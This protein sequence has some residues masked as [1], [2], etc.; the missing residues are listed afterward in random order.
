MLS[1]RPILAHRKRLGHKT[2]PALD[3]AADALK[4][5]KP[6]PPAEQTK[7]NRNEAQQHHGGSDRPQQQRQTIGDQ[8]PRHPA[9]REWHGHFEGI[10]PVRFETNAPKEKQRKPEPSLPRKMRRIGISR[11]GHATRRH[12]TCS[13]AQ[14]TAPEQNRDQADPDPGTRAKEIE[15]QISHPCANPTARVMNLA[16]RASIGPTGVGSIVGQQN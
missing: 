1:Y 11:S 3:R 2:N 4:N 16:R 7:A 9:W 12:F 15:Q 8:I 5:L 13:H 10:K 14:D 6:R